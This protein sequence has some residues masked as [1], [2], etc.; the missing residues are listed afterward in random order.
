VAG[1]DIA[2][3]VIEKAKSLVEYLTI[4]SRFT[5]IEEI[6]DKEGRVVLSVYLPVHSYRVTEGN[7]DKV[8]VW[9]AKGMAKIGGEDIS[10]K[11][12]IG[13]TMTVEV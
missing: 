5:P 6:E 8:A 4:G 1:T 3:E 9:I 11:V 7:R 2:P 13:G 10:A 12:Q